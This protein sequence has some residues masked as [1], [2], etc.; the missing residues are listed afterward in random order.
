MPFFSQ[1]SFLKKFQKEKIFP[2]ICLTSIFEYT[3]IKSR[4]SFYGK[5]SATMFFFKKRRW[6]RN[7]Q[8]EMKKM[9]VYSYSVRSWHTERSTY[10]KTKLV[11]LVIAIMLASM[12]LVSAS[13]GTYGVEYPIT[14]KSC[15]NSK[16]WS[17]A[18]GI[19]LYSLT[20]KGYYDTDGVTI[21]GWGATFS[22]PGIIDPLW[23]ASNATSTW[24]T[25]TN[26]YQAT[27]VGTAKFSG[28]IPV[29][30]I[31]YQSFTESLTAVGRP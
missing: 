11:W 4:N 3:I 23:S 7:A 2:K 17:S 9:C 27:V 25:T 5:L 31:E 21:V 13:A 14:T 15:S 8:E 10:M 12:V 22:L 20:V 29:L 28:S 6:W 24:A 16:T 1:S 19:P 18:L 30:G 26:P